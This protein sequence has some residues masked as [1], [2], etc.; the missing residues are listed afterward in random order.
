MY[1]DPDAE[2]LREVRDVVRPPL[3]GLG[4][5][6]PYVQLRSRPA[7]SRNRLVQALG[8]L[9]KRRQGAAGVAPVDSGAEVIAGE[10]A[11]GEATAGATAAEAPAEQRHGD[12]DAVEVKLRR[13]REW[14]DQ[15]LIDEDEYQVK[16]RELL[17]RL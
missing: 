1:V 7:W 6:R 17:E 11:A 15:G 12:L 4:L 3:M 14:R 13:L 16:R 9:R 2:G 8:F 10:P 5:A